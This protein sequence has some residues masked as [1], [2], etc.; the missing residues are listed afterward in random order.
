MVA[1]GSNG[2]EDFSFGNLVLSLL[3][4][5]NRIDSGLC[6]GAALRGWRN[7]TFH[8]SHMIPYGTDRLLLPWVG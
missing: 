2:G 5:M 1:S 3:D 6:Y 8:R 7:I 4:M